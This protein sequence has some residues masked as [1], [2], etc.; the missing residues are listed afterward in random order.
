MKKNQ[1]RNIVT[2]SL[3]SLTTLLFFSLNINAQVDLDISNNVG[4]GTATPAG[5][6]NV[7]NGSVLFNG[8]TGTTPTSGAGTRMMWVPSKASFRVG[9]VAGSIWDDANIGTSS[10]AF[11]MCYLLYHQ[12]PHLQFVKNL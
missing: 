6:F 9:S 5:K 11:G 2:T 8:T 7:L 10:I 12:L 4:I 3:F 1:L